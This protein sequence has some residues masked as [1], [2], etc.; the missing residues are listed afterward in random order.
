MRRINFTT[1]DN[2]RTDVI[3]DRL[4]AAP[5]F[6]LIEV[7]I[8]VTVVA[9]IASMVGPMLGDT[10]AAQLRAAAQMVVADLQFAQL[11]SVSHGE[12][13]RVVVF[14]TLNGTYH[15]GTA[16]APATPITNPIDGKD[17]VVQFG[18]GRASALSDVSI[19]AHALDGDDRVGFGIYGQLDQTVAATVTLAAAGNT[20]TITLDP[21]TGEASVGAILP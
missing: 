7:L 10:A 15:V 17:Y 2:H 11:A 19:S 12:D 6:T 8:V 14:D 18:S 1:S 21:V 3:P 16:T 20:V 13:T 4:V 9:I 5:A